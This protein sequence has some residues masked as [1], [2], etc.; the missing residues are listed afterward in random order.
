MLVLKN[1]LKPTT[2]MNKHHFSL[3][4]FWFVMT[5]FNNADWVGFL[6]ENIIQR[7]VSLTQTE[8]SGC[9]DGVKCDILHLH[10]QQS[11]L[12]KVQNHFEAARGDVLNHL[13]DLYKEME[14]KLPHSSDMRKDRSIY[15]G[16]GR[17]FLLTISPQALYY[18]R[19][20]NELNHAVITEVLENRK[21]KKRFKKQVL[22]Q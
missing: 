14:E 9:K 3:N 19:Y 8:C 5:F 21:T 18:G 17:F 11:L 13:C 4:T 2:F 7:C 20:V 16:V 12:D 15:C 6:A 22:K 10:H 1:S